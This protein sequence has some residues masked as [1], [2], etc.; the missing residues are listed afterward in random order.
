MAEVIVIGTQPEIIRIYLDSIGSATIASASFPNVSDLT[1]GTPTPDNTTTPRSVLVQVSGQRSGK[2]YQAEPT[3]ALSAGGPVT[4]GVT[5][6]CIRQ[7]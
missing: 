6:Y 1:F 4:R 7:P 2:A 5:V 3:F